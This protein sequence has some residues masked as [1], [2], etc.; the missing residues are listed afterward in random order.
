MEP[1]EEM[2]Q[3]GEMLQQGSR[4]LNTQDFNT[5]FAGLQSLDLF[6][7]RPP[8]LSSKDILF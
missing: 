4:C 7:E 1:T 6:S 5:A 3:K 8:H 2:A